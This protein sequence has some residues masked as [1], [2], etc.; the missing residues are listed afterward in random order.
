MLSNHGT[1]ALL[2]GDL[3]LAQKSLD[4]ASR[5]NDYLKD[6]FVRSNILIGY[7]RIAMTVGDYEQSHI[8]LQEAEEITE[9]LG[10]RLHLLFIRTHLGFLALR[11]GNITEAHHLFVETATTF[12]RDNNVNAIVFALEGMAGF[13][14]ATN[15]PTIAARLIGW[16][17]AT[18]KEIEDTRPL[19]E[20]A[21]VDKIIAACIIKMGEVAFSDA[22]DAGKKMTLDEAVAY[23]L[24]EN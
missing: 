24:E 5:L 21:D 22:Y 15:K 20:Q 2:D 18:R 9:D 4:E 8:Y 12:Q 6:K 19:L 10:I 16:S 1:S 11:E 7:G 14:V 17:D 3:E 23:A 13:Y